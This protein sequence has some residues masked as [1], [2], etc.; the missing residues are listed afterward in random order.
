MGTIRAN[1]IEIT[2]RAKVMAWG[3]HLFTASGVVWGM[4]SLLAIFEHNWSL[5][6][7]WMGAALVVDSLDGFMAR[8]AHVKIVLP[9]FDGA[10]LDNMVDYLNYVFVPAL[11][12]YYSNVLPANLILLGPAA[13]LLA[14][15]YQFC[16]TNAKTEDHFFVGFPSYWNVVVFYL[17]LVDINPW[18]SLAIILALCVLVFVPFK[19]IYPTRTV[20]FQRFTLVVVGIWGGAN[21]ALLIQYPVVNPQIV[22]VSLACGAYY[23]GM[24]VFLMIDSKKRSIA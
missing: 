22:A 24:S 8:K 23:W 18:V 10:L 4:L 16:Q 13:I 5:A 20:R 3:V 14:S 9:N 21:L 2:D 11:F 15:A 7:V 17:L 19:Y 1:Q 12:L 6:F